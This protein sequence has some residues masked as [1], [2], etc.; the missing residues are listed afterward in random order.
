MKLSV[1]LIACIVCSVI[2]PLSGSIFQ[3]YAQN[4]VQYKVQ[5]EL[6]SSAVWTI[7][8]ASNLDDTIETWQ[9][10]QQRTENIVYESSIQTQRQMRLDPDS[11]Q[12]NTV[13]ENQSHTTE[14]QFTWLNFSII[15]DGQISFGDVFRTGFFDQLYGDGELQISYPLTYKVESISPQPNGISTAP[16]MLD[17]LGTQFFVDG[18]PSITLVPEL[19]SPSPDHTMDN[20]DWQ[21]YVALGVSAFAVIAAFVSLFLA[22][23]RARQRREETKPQSV[24]IP[25]VETDEE[26]IVKLIRANGGSAFQTAIG[27]QLRFSKA[28]TSQLLSAL[29]N[30]GVVARYKKGRDKIVTL[31][32]QGRSDS[33]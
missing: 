3:A 29:E 30:K 22:R 12:M 26:K 16:Q 19:T 1:I 24:T 14:F 18:S 11:L 10:F 6:D 33:P 4:F 32:A 13:W 7:I 25:V 5:I 23:R 8:Q 20:V 21:F 31:A 28:K 17:Y 27:E 2:L 15:Q 9:S